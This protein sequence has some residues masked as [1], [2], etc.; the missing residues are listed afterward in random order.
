MPRA[1]PSQIRNSTGSHKA[2]SLLAKAEQISWWRT[3]RGAEAVEQPA[4]MLSGKLIL[5]GVLAV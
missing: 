3:I 1:R 4:P 2:L 5:G